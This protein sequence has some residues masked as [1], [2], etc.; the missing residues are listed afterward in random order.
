M[1][2]QVLK[3]ALE[4]HGMSTVMEHYRDV[5]GYAVE[6]V[7]RWESYDIRATRGTEE[8]HIEVKGSS[9][10]AGHVEL[11]Y[12]EVGH[13]YG[14]DTHLVIVDEIQWRRLLDGTIETSG[15]RAANRSPERRTRL[16]RGL[17]P[18]WSAWVR[19]RSGVDQLVSRDAAGIIV[20]LRSPHP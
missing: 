8:L 20:S 14:T 11:T 3:V 19:C 7:S 18:M 10:S 16:R 1:A 2:D 9:G 6:D 4:Q 13:A 12:N 17:S 15:G 5:E